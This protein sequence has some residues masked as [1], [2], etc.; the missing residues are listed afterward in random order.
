MTSASMTL[1]VFLGYLFV[2]FIMTL[3]AGSFLTKPK[4]FVSEY[5]LGGRSMASWTLALSF[6]ATCISG[7]TFAGFPSLIYTHGWVLF[8]WIG[9]YML[10]PVFTMG[11]MGK[12]LNQISHRMSAVTIPDVIRDRYQSTALGIFAS[13]AIIFFLMV[14]LI[15]QFKSGG[16]IL[17]VLMRD[18]FSY[19]SYV[20]PLLQ[21]LPI[22]GPAADKVGPGYVF[23]LIL[24]SIVTIVYTSYGGFR[25][26]VW[27]DTMQG[28]VMFI[29]VVIL[30]PVVLIKAGGLGEV[31]RKLATMPPATVI[32]TTPLN[33]AMEYTAAEGVL[34]PVYVEHFSGPN[35][36]PTLEVEIVPPESGEGKVVR[37]HVKAD[38]EGKI[39][40]NAVDVAAA[41]N[42]HP[43]ATKLL[44]AKVY[45]LSEEAGKGAVST[46]PAPKR[47]VPGESR[48]YGPSITERGG[49]FHPLGMA[50]SFFVLWCF[51]GAGHPGFLVR[52]M[53]FKN[54]RDL[55][56]SIVTVTFYFAIV[57]IPLV[58]IFVAART[59]IHPADL[60]GGSD[61]IMPTVAKSLVHPLLAGLLIAAPFSAVMSTVEAFL[62]TVS[63]SFVRD[64]YQRTFHP[65]ASERAIKVGSYLITV[66]VGV[67]V[68]FLSLDPPPFLQ[69]IVVFSSSGISATFLV[70]TFLGIYWKRMTTT[71]AWA[72]MLSGFGIVIAAHLP[73][74]LRR[75]GLPGGGNAIVLFGIDAFVWACLVS[76][77]LGVAVSYCSAAPSHEIVRAYF[78]RRSPAASGQSESKE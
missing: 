30:L 6:A 19:E 41:V 4:S 54:S 52:L 51:S 26:V 77:I 8:L 43:A 75:F 32:G 17:D 34:N 70:A 73:I 67:V 13:F 14:N 7:G 31:T 25:A 3:V 1:L 50:L 49:A 23:S 36:K 5:F 62:L 27:T 21:S 38:G 57:Y 74:I 16:M 69:D 29:G 65:N 64:I 45:G 44:K 47:L 20:V 55:R 12:R 42:V 59:L 15:A 68:M 11:L 72:A 61:E 9:S 24:F 71:A 78:G 63:S 60:T 37:V 48:V 35:A 40:S 18:A 2:M 46:T 22:L 76:L 66:I 56:Y 33:N 53:A 10:F 39:R 58:F 28:I